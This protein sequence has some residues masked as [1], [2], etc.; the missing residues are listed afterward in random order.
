GDL[1][2]GGGQALL[3]GEVGDDLLAGTA[4]LAIQGAVG[5]DARLSVGGPDEPRPFFP[6]QFAPGMPAVPTVPSGLTFGSDAS[7]AGNLEYTSTQAASVPAGVVGGQTLFTQG[8]NQQAERRE[9]LSAVSYLLG[10]LRRFLALLLVGSLL[11]WLAR[12]P[13]KRSVETLE[14]QPL[15]SLGWGL[16]AMVLILTAFVAVLALTILLAG[17]FGLFTL[18]ALATT[19]VFLGMLVLA[20]LLLA[21]AVAI[22][23]LAPIAVSVWIGRRI[24]GKFRPSAAGGRFGPYVLGLLVYVVVAGIPW[25]GPLVALAVA[26]WG[27]GAWALAVKD[28]RHD[29]RVEAAPEPSWF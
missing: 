2:W 14:T 24:L 4:A 10:R 22:V 6:T 19:V 17:I 15:A 21:A 26:V 9:T 7:I 27:L 5:G 25:I 20:G 13:L 18:Q 8:T 16:L 12:R 29:I 3:A 1:M 28:L 11:L 23:W